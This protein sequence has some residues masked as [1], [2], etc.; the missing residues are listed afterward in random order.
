MRF[1]RTGARSEVPT[2]GIIGFEIPRYCALV[3]H[4]LNDRVPVRNNTAVTH[5]APK[6]SVVGNR[7]VHVSRPSY[8]RFT[9]F[10]SVDVTALTYKRQQRESDDDSSSPMTMMLAGCHRDK[11]R[12]FLFLHSGRREERFLS[13]SAKFSKFYFFFYYSTLTPTNTAARRPRG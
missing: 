5:V 13:L 12:R 7:S 6:N 11:R 2:S 10:Y 3:N 9:V 1:S 4:L 8:I